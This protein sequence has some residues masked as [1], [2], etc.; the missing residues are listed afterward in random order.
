MYLIFQLF[1]K[2][3]DGGLW[4]PL[5]WQDRQRIH[6]DFNLVASI[7]QTGGTANS[8]RIHY[9]TRI[10]PSAAIIADLHYYGQ[11]YAPELLTP[12]LIHHTECLLEN[13]L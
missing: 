5:G 2:R 13:K 3:R 9:M 1:L 10:F 7:V 6:T 4:H 8:R 12:E 11:N